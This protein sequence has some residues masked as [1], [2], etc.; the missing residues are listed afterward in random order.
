MDSGSEVNAMVFAYISKL[1][2]KIWAINIK[3]Q[4]IDD[5]IFQ[6]FKIVCTSFQVENKLGKACFFQQNFLI[7]NT[8]I[9]MI[10]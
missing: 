10:L 6:I 8:N 2:F 4:K 9:E 3:A 5:S 7:A 1:G